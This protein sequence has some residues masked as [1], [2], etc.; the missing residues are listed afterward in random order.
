MMK[1]FI[2]FLREE[3]QVERFYGLDY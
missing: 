1:D 2:P 3:Y